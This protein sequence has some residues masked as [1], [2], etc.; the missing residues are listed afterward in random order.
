MVVG[1]YRYLSVFSSCDLV[2]S[3]SST[4]E[5]RGTSTLHDSVG[6]LSL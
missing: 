6:R 4:L 2:L 3:T 5:E 1:V